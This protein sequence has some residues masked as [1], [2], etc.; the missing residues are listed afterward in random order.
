MR[1][2]HTAWL[3]PL[4]LGRTKKCQIIRPRKGP[5]CF[6]LL[7]K[8]FDRYMR[9]M[10]STGGNME[11]AKRRM[12]FLGP[13]T[14]RMYPLERL[15][16][17]VSITLQLWPTHGTSRGSL[18]GLARTYVY[19]QNVWFKHERNGTIRPTRRCLELR[20]SNTASAPSLLEVVRRF[21]M[22][23]LYL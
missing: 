15:E 4:S 19:A 10:G 14:L 12:T 20:M 17:T 8:A 2:I 23:L 22:H 3:R 13:T 21:T 16:T 9:G 6:A 11:N 5:I 18:G 7:S 1:R